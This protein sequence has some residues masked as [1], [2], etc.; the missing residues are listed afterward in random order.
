[1]S[2]AIEEL[3]EKIANLDANSQEHLLERV[4]VLNFQNGLTKL[5]QQYK[6]RLKKE[7]RL[8]E[9]TEEILQELRRVRDEIAAKDYGKKINEK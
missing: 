3:A 2:T 7:K 6:A 9:N 8:N 1:M 4:A 5:S